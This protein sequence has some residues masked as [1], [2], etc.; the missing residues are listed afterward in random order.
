MDA[1]TSATIAALVVAILAMIVAMLQAAQ[2][3]IVTGQLIRLCDS[4]VLGRCRGKDGESGKC[5]NS[6]FASSV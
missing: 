4:V 6:G 5:I 2:Q 1:S 3:Y